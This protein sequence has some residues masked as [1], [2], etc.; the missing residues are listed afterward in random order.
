MIR[1][2]RE[3]SLRTI[4]KGAAVGGAAKH[5]GS[6]VTGAG[7]NVQLLK[8]VK[9]REAG[10]RYAPSLCGMSSTP[11]S[12]YLLKDAGHIQ[13]HA[14][15]NRERSTPRW[16]PC[17]GSQNG[18]PLKSQHSHSHQAGPG[19]RALVHHV[20]SAAAG[21]Y[22]VQIS[23]RQLMGQTQNYSIAICGC[24]VLPVILSQFCPKYGAAA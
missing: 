4:G 10:W 7:E 6:S 20:S 8:V 24:S 14:G 23:S 13:P 3:F 2:S 19:P 12:C 22:L 11:H 16:L 9:L 18:Q 5:I 1:S 15:S 21:F 17:M